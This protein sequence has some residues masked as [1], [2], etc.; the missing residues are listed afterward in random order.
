[1]DNPKSWA[2]RGRLTYANGNLES[3]KAT[4]PDPAGEIT[5]GP[6]RVTEESLGVRLGVWGTEDDSGSFPAAGDNIAYAMKDLLVPA[7]TIDEIVSYRPDSIHADVGDGFSFTL[8]FTYW[9]E[10]F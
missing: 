8:S 6:E 10:Y 3:G 7:G 9:I 1:V 4:T 5:V 2:A